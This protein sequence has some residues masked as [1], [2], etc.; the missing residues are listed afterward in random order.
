MK[1][2]DD[3]DEWATA[4][5]ANAEKYESTNPPPGSSWSD[6]EDDEATVIIDEDG[7]H[8]NGEDW[9][10]EDMKEAKRKYKGKK[11]HGYFE[12]YFGWNN[13]FDQDGMA[14]NVDARPLT[15]TELNFLA[16]HDLGI[17]IR[18]QNALW[19]KQVPDPL[20]G[21]IQLALF[22]AKRR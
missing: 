18:R 19:P 8:I 20:W 5:E 10:P 2:T 4:W 12:M 21:A 13:W 15:T 11:T 16:Q 17:R 9:D 22:P 7:I 14:M 6:D 1:T 3:V